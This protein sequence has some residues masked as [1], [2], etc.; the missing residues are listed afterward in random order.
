MKDIK[1]L[2]FGILGII[3]CANVFAQEVA[4]PTITNYDFQDQSCVNTV[5]DN[6]KWAV[7]FGPGTSNASMYTNARLI[8]IETGE[9]TVLGLEYDEDT[10]VSCMASDVT[11]DGMVVGEYKGRPAT[12]TK[13]G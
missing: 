1:K 5:S 3:V 7:S 4:P 12:W 13:A 10:P 8:N 9:V 2:I 11:D 6:G